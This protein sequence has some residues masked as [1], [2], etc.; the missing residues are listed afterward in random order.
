MVIPTYWGRSRSEPRHPEDVVYDHPTPV[1]ETGTLARAVESFQVLNNKDFEI[2]VLG[3]AAHPS[4]ERQAEERVAAIVADFQDTWRIGSLSFSGARRIQE[5]LESRGHGRLARFVSLYGYP[6][7]RNMCLVA[8]ELR[9]ADVVILFDD[10]QILEDAAYIDKATE[11]IGRKH[12]GRFVGAVAGYYLRAEGGYLAP[13]TEDWWWLEWQGAEAMNEAF[14]LIEGGP[15]LKETPFAFGGNTVIHRDVFRR[16]PFDPCCARGEDIDFLINARMLGYPFVLDNELTIRHLPPESAVPD[17]LGF[18]QNVLR[19]A[20]ERAKI[21]AQREVDGMHRVSVDELQPYPGRFLGPDLDAK[22]ER[23]SVLLAVK[24]VLEG[25][26]MSFSECLENMA[27]GGRV[28]EAAFDPFD[29]F[30]ETQR[31]WVEL[32]SVLGGADELKAYLEA[33]FAGRIDT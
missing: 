27:L 6:N 25:D 7:V 9:D 23:T 12:E 33:A 32:M 18:R 2:I 10:D 30:L 26:E 3:A 22:V 21:N 1:D 5:H 16:V 13:R 17:W 8:A 31:D 20:Y 29:R 14:G 4:L 24:H 19:F 11:F 28:G 15:R